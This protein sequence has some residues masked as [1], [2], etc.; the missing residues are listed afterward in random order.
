[1]VKVIANEIRNGNIIEY[2]SGLW[3]VLDVT[4]TKPG[5]GGA[6]IQVEMKEISRGTK[7]NQRFRS[8][9]NV[10]KAILDEEQYQYLYSDGESIVLMN[11]ETYEQH[12]VNNSLLGKKIVYLH[13]GMMITALVY[14][15]KIININLPKH[16]VL[17]VIRTEV[18]IKGQ[19]AAAGYKPA[20]L[21]KNINIMVPSFIEVGDRLIVNTEDDSYVERK[22]NNN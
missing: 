8:N 13:D 9:E 21:K 14:N 22:K 19:T 18:A 17:T 15:E 6:Y 1:M 5:K 12:I 16:V 7:L 20:M 10:K 11:N 4:H 2:K 3:E